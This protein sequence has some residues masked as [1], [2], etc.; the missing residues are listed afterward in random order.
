M[1]SYGCAILLFGMTGTVYDYLTPL[2]ARWSLLSMVFLITFVLPVLNIYLL[3]RLRRIPSLLLSD[4][5]H[6][7]FPYLI[8]ALFYF[9][10]VY[11]L[12]DVNFWNSIKV[13]VFGA[14]MAIL[15]TALINLRYK[16]SAHLVGFGG[17]LGVLISASM[18]LS[19]DITWM[20]VVLV[21]L[22][23]MVGSARMYLEEHTNG[24]LVSGFVLGLLV[25]LGLFLT[26]R[27][28]S[29]HYIL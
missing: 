19:T 17:L 12:F 28:L 23:G 10:L 2:K 7:G 24:E 5:K 3:Y 18:M 9:G 14:G 25:Q 15:L 21:L 22:A 16:V 27:Q 4:P 20:Y 1:T 29:F 6:R 8:T 13:F 26:L 11:L